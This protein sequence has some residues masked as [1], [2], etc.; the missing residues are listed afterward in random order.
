M[1]SKPLA[2]EQDKV[3]I[4]LSNQDMHLHF[5]KLD[6]I[7]NR[8]NLYLPDIPSIKNLKKNFSS[9]KIYNDKDYFIQQDNSIIYKKI[10]NIF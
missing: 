10:N 8:K 4:Y 6:S 7:K 5:S 2:F 3:A 9:S 1:I